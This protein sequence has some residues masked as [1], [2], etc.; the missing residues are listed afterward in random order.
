M[1]SPSI[2][3]LSGLPPEEYTPR[4]AAS[5]LIG[6]ARDPAFVEAHILPLLAEA[7]DAG[8]WYVARCWES[9]EGSYSLQ[10]FVWPPESRT[11]VHDH[12][13][14]GVFCSVVGTVLEERYERLD[15]GSQLNHARLKK[16]WQR[17][18][19][20]RDGVSTVLPY[21]GGI[22][23]MGNPGSGTAISVHLY[24]PRIGGMDG[25]D[26][27]PSR[28]YVCDRFG[29]ERGES[30]AIARAKLMGEK[31]SK[32]ERVMSE[33]NKEKARR[34]VEEAFG[35]GKVELV[36]EILD[37]DFVC[38]DPNSEAGEVRGAETIKQ[39]ILYFRNAVPDLTY[40]VDDQVAEGDKV[41]TR[42]T[43]SGTHQGEFFG[44]PATGNR[45]EMSGIQIDRFDESGK[46][47][48]EWPEYDMLGAMKQMDALPES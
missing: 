27:E 14:W 28:D 43:A 6:L 5:G 33:A 8:D 39:E 42:Y 4:E 12:T 37:P 47:V 34:M 11:Q 16:V 3:A 32:E 15:D 24:G 30:D 2:P 21:D 36:E 29:D 25:R 38:Y 31:R 20:T 10:V 35:Q 1:S 17:A 41:V 48:E 46:M 13:S 40:T 9:R 7:R 44:V 19:G 26:Y 22:H 23:R 45:I 18:W